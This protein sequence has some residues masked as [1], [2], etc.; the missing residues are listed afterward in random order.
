MARSTLN[1]MSY[2]S[3]GLDS[4]KIDWIQEV[5]K[6]CNIDL[7]QLQEHFKATKSTEAFFRKNF[8]NSY[9]SYVIPAYRE[10]FQDSGR[11]KGGLAQLSSKSCNIKKERIKTKSWRLQAQV[12]HIEEYKI[13]WFNCYMPT[14]PQTI[15][16]DEVELQPVLAEIENIL[17]NNSFDDCILGGDL[18]FDQ[19]RGSGF[20]ACLRNF[21]ERI[22]LKSVWEKFPAD[23]THL[24]TDMRS[25]SIIDHFFVSQKLL[26]LV[27][28]AGPVHLGDNRSRHSPIMMKVNVV[29]LKSE[30][31]KQVGAPQVRKPAWYKATEDDKNEYTTVLASKLAN[32][33]SP[34]SLACSDVNCQ[35]EEHTRDRD[36]HVLDVMFAIMEASHECIPLSAK[37]RPPGKGKR[38]NH[39]GWKENVAPAKDD[40]L[41]WHGVWRSAGRPNTG[42]LYQVMCW[43]RNQFHYAVR[44]AKRLAANI[45]ARKLLEAAEE[46]NIALM[47]EMRNTLG[48]KT[49]G[50]AVPETLDGKVT[51]DSILDRFRECYEQLYNSAGTGDAMAIIKEKLANLVQ[52]NSAQSLKEVHKVTGK[53]VKE[54]CSRMLPG[55]TDV[56][57]VYSSDVF[58]NAP[59]ILF[60]QLASVFRSYLVHGTVSLQILSCA[61]LPLFK[62]GLKN[63]AVFDSYRAI[64]GASQLLKLFEYVILLAWGDSLQSDSMQFG[65]KSGVSTTQCTWVVNE[66][67]TFFMRRGTAVNACLLDCSKAFDKCL[68]AKLFG[69]LIAKGLPAVVI[70]VLVFVYEEQQGCVKLGGK[71]S[72]YFQLTNGTRQGSVLSPVLFSV[73]LDDLLIELRRLQLGCHIGGWWYGAL[74]YADDLILLAPNREVLQKMLVVCEQYGVEHNLVFS[75]DPVPSLSKTKCMYFC[76]RNGNVKYPAPVILDGKPLPWVD[77]AVHLGHVLHQSVSMEQDCHRARA[78]FIDKSVDVRQQFYFAQPSQVLD[79]VQILCTDAYGSMLWDLQSNPAEQYFK[80]W[81]TCVKLVHDVPRS[82]YTYLVEGYLAREQTSL[83][84]QV[85]SR[86]PGFYRKL[87]SSPS[88]EVRMLVKMVSKDPRSI[89]CR[90][91]KYLSLKTGL[92][93]PHS[94]GSWKVRE[95]LPVQKV[96]MNEMWRLGLLAKLMEMRRNKF[97]EVKDSQRITAMIDS[98]CST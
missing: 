21:L 6:T 16:Y 61:F 57:E 1:F 68:F 62:G 97:M 48:R 23:Y 69:K 5:S 58:I 40:A 92:E 10:Q 11:A 19:R 43:S 52:G 12:L 59:D 15:M 82:T 91:L 14:D 3:T 54:A 84:T 73:Y 66:V 83:R 4:T 36:S 64:A 24:H 77:H 81:N 22:G 95:A 26:E 38:E 49:C 45:K 34:D 72:A 60:E 41:F 93:Q 46:G 42:G 56:S 50:Q 65:F 79:M 67:A 39:P 30:C 75:T 7:L 37:I 78:R 20:A 85:L 70:R 17:D 31:P 28:D 47:K 33:V 96:P 87:L 32:I 35:A 94:Y 2:N 13:L 89:T 51:H 55:K 88:K 63:P 18:N 86:Y 8:E 25:S 71:R 76:G 27:E 9:D 74:G 98:L 90:N 44:R 29:G 80:C 53:L